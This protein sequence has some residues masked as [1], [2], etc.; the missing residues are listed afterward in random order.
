MSVSLQNQSFAAWELHTFSLWK[1]YYIIIL[2][3]YLHRLPCNYVYKT[4]AF[5]ELP[6]AYMSYI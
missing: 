1:I 5:W 6:L 2:H 4:S 3:I